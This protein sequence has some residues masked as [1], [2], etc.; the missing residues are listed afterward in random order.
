[1]RIKMWVCSACGAIWHVAQ[2]EARG[3]CLSCNG[4]GGV[5]DCEKDEA[6]V[7]KPVQK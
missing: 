3:R 6:G 1:M 2:G 4:E 7:V 5:R